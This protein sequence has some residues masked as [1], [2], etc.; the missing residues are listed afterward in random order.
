MEDKSIYVLFVFAILIHNIE[1]ALWLPGWSSQVRP[2]DKVIDKSE[3]YFAVLIITVLAVLVT[4]AFIIFPFVNLIKYSYFGF[5]AAMIINVFAPHLITTI[6]FRKYTPGLITGVLLICPINGYIIF[7][8]LLVGILS[9]EEL[10]FSTLVVG[11][12][13]LL[14]L[15]LLFKMS[16]II[17]KY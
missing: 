15:P 3:F 10:I 16:K 12:M 5:L 13:L 1:E 2:K 4:S 14:S 7:R 9:W 6:S 17:K 11:G 8:A